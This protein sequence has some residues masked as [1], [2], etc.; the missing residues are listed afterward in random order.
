MAT[1][2]FPITHQRITII[3]VRKPVRRD[4]NEELQWFGNSL[5]LFNLRDKDRSC[6]RIFIELLQAAKRNQ[7]LTS[8][9]LAY[10][11]SLS[12]GTVIHHLDKLL[13]AGLVVNER[14]QYFLRV[15]TLEA[16]VDEIEKDLLRA[17]DDLRKVAREI[18]GELEL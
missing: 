6:F 8:D 12:R 5:G 11:T 14:N 18:D 13:D 15:G 1:I 17:C 10:K 9:E 3:R 7:P 2:S 4:L 16:V